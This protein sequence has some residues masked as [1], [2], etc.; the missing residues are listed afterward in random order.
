VDSLLIHRLFIDC[1]F[2]FIDGHFGFVDFARR[3]CL[4]I[5][6]L[7]VSTYRLYCLFGFVE[8]LFGIID[9]STL[10]DG[11]VSLNLLCFPTCTSSLISSLAS[12]GFVCMCVQKSVVFVVFV[13]MYTNTK[14]KSPKTVFVICVC[15]S[16]Y[17]YVCVC[18]RAC[19]HVHMCVFLYVCKYV[20]RYLWCNLNLKIISPGSRT[21]D[22]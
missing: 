21:R 9:L 5:F 6:S 1:F 20:C 14:K 15:I 3:R 17:M 10:R 2:G 11:V 22:V 16:V 18:V 12:C 13:Y 8:I 19:M 7:D 4:F